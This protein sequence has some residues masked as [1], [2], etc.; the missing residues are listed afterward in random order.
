ML[1]TCCIDICRFM[2]IY[3]LYMYITLHIH[4]YIKFTCSCNNLWK[5]IVYGSGKSLEK[6]TPGIFSPTLWSVVSLDR[7]TAGLWQH[8]LQL[9]VTPLHITVLSLS[10]IISDLLEPD[11]RICPLVGLL[12]N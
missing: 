5:S 8:C 10:V 6:K 2:Y 11:N 9:P 3:I 7:H 1:V 4:K 12:K